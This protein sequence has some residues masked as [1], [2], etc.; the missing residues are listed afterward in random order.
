MFRASDRP[1]ALA[2]ALTR[3]ISDSVERPI[4]TLCV[5]RRHIP[6]TAVVCVPYRHIHGIKESPPRQYTRLNATGATECSK[7]TLKRPADVRQT[8]VRVRLFTR[9]TLLARVF[10]IAKCLSVRPS[11]TSRYCVKTKKASVMISSPSGSATILV[12]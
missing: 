6:C 10:A 4:G 9:A 8:Y 12:F 5:N 3:I 11:V 1:I 2:G 7:L